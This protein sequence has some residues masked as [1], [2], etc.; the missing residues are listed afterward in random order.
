MKPLTPREIERYLKAGGFRL[1]RICGSH[2]IWENNAGR[3]VPVPHHGN[4]PLR[5]PDPCALF[6]APDHAAMFGGESGRG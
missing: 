1:D 3:S 2:Y 6:L 4:R 5:A